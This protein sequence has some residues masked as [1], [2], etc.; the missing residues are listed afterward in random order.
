MNE[1]SEKVALRMQTLAMDQTLSPPR[2]LKRKGPPLLSGD[3]AEG[4]QIHPK[5]E[6]GCGS[7]LPEHGLIWGGP[8]LS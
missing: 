5:F 2:G 7:H 4:H 6:V 3:V 1:L 8:N